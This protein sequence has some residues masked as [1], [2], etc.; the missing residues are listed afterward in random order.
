MQPALPQQSKASLSVP[1]ISPLA[2]VPAIALTEPGAAGGVS[3]VLL[4]RVHANLWLAASPT[5]NQF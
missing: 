1:M 4:S 3:S 2:D 5:E